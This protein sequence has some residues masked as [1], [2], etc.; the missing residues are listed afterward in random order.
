MSA[1]TIVGLGEILW[2]F[3]PTGKHLGGFAANVAYHASTLGDRGVVL[4]TVGAD[5]LGEE[6]VRF[7]RS[8]GVDVSHVQRDPIVSTGTVS[9]SVGRHGHPTFGITGDVAWD[10]MRYT[11][12]WR[13][14]GK[15]A[16]AVCFGTLAQRSEESRAAMHAFLHELPED[17]LVVYDVNVRQFFYT[18]EIIRTSLDRADVCKLNEQELPTVA[19]VLRIPV[20]TAAETAQR[21]REQFDLRCVAVTRGKRGGTVVSA[22]EI[23]DYPGFAVDVKDSVGAGDAFTAG[24]IHG[25]LR[26]MDLRTAFRIGAE[27][28]AWV[29]SHPG[30]MP[31]ASTFD[32]AM[33]A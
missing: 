16:D 14:A 17:C 4:G 3:L 9:I 21:L 31:H 11:D 13:E 30:G 18:P 23:V 7:L 25:L 5:A 22:D 12:D 33:Y 20:T 8:H 24:F 29:A 15:N 6:A 27:R 26:S 32:P 2:D 28:G 1:F 19:S 10:H